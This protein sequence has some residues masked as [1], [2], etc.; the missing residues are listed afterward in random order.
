MLDL[1]GER[2]HN[3]VSDNYERLDV[4]WRGIPQYPSDKWRNA[5]QFH[6]IRPVEDN[7][8][9]SVFILLRQMNDLSWQQLP[10]V[11][12][13]SSPFFANVK[14]EDI[15]PFKIKSGKCEDF[16]RNHNKS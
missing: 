12:T 8:N 4:A 7:N 15:K 13:V 1:E 2:N 6:T 9:R 11:K 16:L 3:R 5:W 10:T 14:G